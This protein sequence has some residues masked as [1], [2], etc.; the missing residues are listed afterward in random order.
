M[1]LEEVLKQLKLNKSRDP[2]G[3]SNKLFKPQ[4]AGSDWKEVILCLIDQ[5]KTQQVFPTPLQQCNI[6]SLY[7]NKGKRHDFNNYRGIFRVKKKRSILDKL[8]YNDEY[9]N[10]DKH[11]T[12]SNVRA[13]RGRNIRDNIFVLSAIQNQIVKKKLKAIDVGVYDIGKCFDKLWAK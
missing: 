1:D 7:K 13:R 10:I 2:M 8:I 6:T 4:N 9:L 5:I 11:L 12:D 3:L